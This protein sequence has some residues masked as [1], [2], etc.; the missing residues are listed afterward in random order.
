MPTRF[1]RRK[2]IAT[3]R[4]LF[5][6]KVLVIQSQN[7][8]KKSKITSEESFA[9]VHE[10]DKKIEECR[11]YDERERLQEE[12]LQAVLNL[13]PRVGLPCTIRY[14][15][16]YR[17]ATIVAMPTPNKVIVRHNEVECLDYYAGNYKILPTIAEY[18]GEEVFTKRRNRL[19]VQEGQSTRD[20]TR[21][22]LHI[23]RHYIDPHY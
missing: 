10:Y 12:R 22:L 15:S 23:H 21:L 13:V 5:Y 3:Q 8:E 4:L 16:D 14:F 19:W 7:M 6:R 9:I 18:M 17:A 2:S 20:G 1:C 11:D